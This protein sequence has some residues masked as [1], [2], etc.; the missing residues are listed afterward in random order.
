MRIAHVCLAGAYSEGMS[1][2]DNS[3][4]E[5]NCADGHEVLIVSD[6]RRF[7]KNQLVRTD[8]EDRTLANGARLVRLP[9]DWAGPTALADKI[10]RCSRLYPMLAAFRPD[11]ILYHGVVGIELLTLRRFKK[12][13]PTTRIYVDSHEDVHNSGTTF[14]SYYGQYRLLTRWLIHRAL[15]VI[16]KIFYIS[17]ETRDWL[18]DVLDLPEDVLEYYPL[19]GLIVD[20]ASRAERRQK[21]RAAQGLADDEVVFLHTGKIDARKRSPELLTAFAAQQGAKS[22]LIIAGTIES[23]MVDTLPALIDAD[24]RIHFIGWQSP[25]AMTDAMCGADV[26]V[27]PGGQSATLQNAICCGMPIIVYPHKSHQ[28][29]VHGNGFYADDAA[30]IEKAIDAIMTF[31]AQLDAMRARSYAI[32]RDVLDYRKLAARLY[33]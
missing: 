24:P 33:V 8:P 6:C 1:Y 9:F 31:P 4:V 2:Q 23:D 15:P 30:A 26:Y 18:T 19:G 21:W 14:L 3:L 22:R 17:L 11:V 32:A 10:K 12:A 20:E 5:I 16:D 27:Q 7:E 13:Y 25:D 29:L 28:P